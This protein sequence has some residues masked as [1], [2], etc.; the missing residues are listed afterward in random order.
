[1]DE[2]FTLLNAL[3]DIRK[4][5]QV[6]EKPML[7]DLAGEVAKLKT[8]HDCAMKVLRQISDRKRKTT[9]QRL[10]SSCVSFLENL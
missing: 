5:L 3:C 4:A 8:R 7:A 6:G 2:E 9:E 1:M 10:A